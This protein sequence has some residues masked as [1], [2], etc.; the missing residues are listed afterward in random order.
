MLG[1]GILHWFS[2][3]IPGNEKIWM[4][5]LAMLFGGL[6]FAAGWLPFHAVRSVNRKGL[7]ITLAVAAAIA[8]GTISFILPGMM[9]EMLS[10]GRFNATATVM[11]FVSGLFFVAAAAFFVARYIAARNSQDLLFFYFSGLTGVAELAFR[12]GR[13]WGGQWWAW[14]TFRLAG[15]VALLAY[16]VLSLKKSEDKNK[17]TD[18]NFR[19]ILRTS[20]DGFFTIDSEGR[21]IGANDVYCLFIG[22]DREEILRMT[23]RDIECDENPEEVARHMKKIIETGSDRF[24]T[25]HRRKDGQIINIEASVHYLPQGQF[26]VFVHDIRARKQMLAALQRSEEELSAILENIPLATAIMDARL[27]AVR[28]NAAMVGLARYTEDVEGQ[29]IGR[30]FRCLYYSFDPAG[31]GKHPLCQTCTGRA[32]LTDTLE[33]QRNHFQ[34]E[35]KLP[36]RIGNEVQERDV[37]V[38]TVTLPAERKLVLLC[39]EDVSARKKLHQQLIMNDRLASIG[40]LASGVAHEIG[41]PLTIIAGYANTIPL[42]DDLPEGAKEGLKIIT[43]ESMRAGDILKNLLTFARAESVTKER[44]NVNGSI[45]RVLELRAHE[46]KVNN[47]TTK[48]NLAP[49]LPEIFGNRTQLEQVFYN[50]VVNAEF[51]MVDSHKQG[52]LT[53]TSMSDGCIVRI[54]FADDGAGIS[55]ENLSRIFT[56]FFTTKKIGQGTGLGLSICLGIVADHG[57][58]LWAESDAGKGATFFIELPVSNGQ[59]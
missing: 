53:V 3:G 54:A 20:M 45:R 55:E 58:R 51:S 59:R 41:N 38:S 2:S 52:N 21:F 39:L 30:I 25:H 26:F 43:E 18:E 15:C 37:L 48:L 50:I 27:C 44:L 8:L 11:N 40:L 47:I 5:S 22:Y 16:A 19:N 17:I 10:G 7:I 23:I 13:E 12:F 35:W 31:C 34:E 9:P 28:A 24:E 29:C 46:Q 36:A 6:C 14:H 33:N 42:M 4:L 56:P 1:M 49:D 57:G 32:L